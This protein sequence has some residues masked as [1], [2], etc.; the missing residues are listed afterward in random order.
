MTKLD[1]LKKLAG[2]YWYIAVAP[3]TE[4]M[5]IIMDKFHAV[6]RSLR[7]EDL[8]PNKEGYNGKGPRY[9]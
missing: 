4:A 7:L 1:A 6:R 2:A 8:A 5:V 3:P 9:F